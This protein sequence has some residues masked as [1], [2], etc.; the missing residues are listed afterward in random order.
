[1]RRNLTAISGFKDF[2]TEAQRTTEKTTPGIAGFNGR[3]AGSSQ[4]R[5]FCV[6]VRLC[7]SRSG[8]KPSRHRPNLRRTAEESVR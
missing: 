1:M 8:W 5:V 3:G 2:T 7:I 6:P 4:V